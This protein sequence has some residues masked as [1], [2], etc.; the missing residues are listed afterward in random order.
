M[1]SGDVISNQYFARGLILTVAISLRTTTVVGTPALLTQVIP[2]GFTAARQTRVG[3]VAQD[4]GTAVLA[5]AEVLTNGT[6]I[7]YSKADGSAWSASTNLTDV[8]ANFT[9]EILD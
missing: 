3:I 1:E 6:T 4:N 9:F 8:D 5:Y 2:G 7:Q